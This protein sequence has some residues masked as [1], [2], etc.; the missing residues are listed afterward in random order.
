MQT[1]LK[2]LHVMYCT[3]V[4]VSPSA[5]RAALELTRAR[6]KRS[7]APRFPPITRR[8]FSFLD[9]LRRHRHVTLL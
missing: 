1:K 6:G 9:L 7:T 2:P 5:W 4:P 8:V 3:R